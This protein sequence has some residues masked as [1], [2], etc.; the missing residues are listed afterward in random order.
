MTTTTTE[1]RRQEVGCPTHMTTAFRRTAEKAQQKMLVAHLTDRNQG[2]T[3]TISSH[4]TVKTK[5]APP[6]WPKN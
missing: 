3:E 4:R 1:D 2:E 5:S 6:T